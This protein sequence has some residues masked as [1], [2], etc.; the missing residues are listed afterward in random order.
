ML[1]TVAKQ[2]SRHALT[3]RQRGQGRTAHGADEWP[4]AEGRRAQAEPKPNQPALTQEA[5]AV[6]RGRGSRGFARSS[7]TSSLT[8]GVWADGRPFPAFLAGA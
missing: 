5:N 2:K 8:R 6:T 1:S 4:G 7:T 3:S